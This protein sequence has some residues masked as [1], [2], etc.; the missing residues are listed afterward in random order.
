[1][2]DKILEVID[3]LD[4][5]ALVIIP[6]IYVGIYNVYLKIKEKKKEVDAKNTKRNEDK[7][8]IWEHEES[9]DVIHSIKTLCNVYKDKS[10]ADLVQY[11]QLEN[12]TIATSRIQNMFVSCLAED[13]RYGSIPKLITKLQRMPYSET[14]EWLSKLLD[15]KSTGKPILEVPDVSA[16]NYSRTYVDNIN[17]V[18]S[19]LVSPVYDPEELLIGIC[20]FYYHDKDFNNQLKSERDFLEKFV[21]AIES[22]ILNYHIHREDKKKELGLLTKED[23]EM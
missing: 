16:V 1:M 5:L 2:F 9:R 3:K 14:V 13:D 4:S 7:Y 11:L 23:K 8:N 10:H 17:F 6:A 22:V 21:I 18:G 19:V 12:G 20:I 15:I